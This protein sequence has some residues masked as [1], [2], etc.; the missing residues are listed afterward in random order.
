MSRGHC[1]VRS[2]SNYHQSSI[3]LPG[4]LRHFTVFGERQEVLPKSLLPRRRGWKSGWEGAGGAGVFSA[5]RFGDSPPLHL[6]LLRLSASF[7]PVAFLRRMHQKQQRV[8]ANGWGRGRGAWFACSEG[9]RGGQANFTQDVGEQQQR[10]WGG[11]CQAS[12]CQKVWRNLG[13][14]ISCHD[15]SC[16]KDSDMKMSYL[17]LLYSNGK[18]QKANWA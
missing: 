9:R 1:L 5:V 7:V 4:H 12:F 11:G 17:S 8:A 3:G 14:L 6:V 15:F 10:R 16:E 13:I 18:C 2:S